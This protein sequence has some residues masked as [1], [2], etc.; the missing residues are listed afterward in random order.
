MHETVL[1]GDCSPFSRGNPMTWR[2]PKRDLLGVRRAG[3]MVSC[4]CQGTSLRKGKSGG[5]AQPEESCW[6]V[7][8]RVAPGNTE[9]LGLR[10]QEHAVEKHASACK[11]GATPL[12]KI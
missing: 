2:L 11:A 8:V 9:G 5:E 6:Y 4:G 1:T 7:G 12:V 3:P 10:P